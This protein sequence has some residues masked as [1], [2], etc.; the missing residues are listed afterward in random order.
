MSSGIYDCCAKPLGAIFQVCHRCEASVC[1]KCKP[2]TAAPLGPIICKE[3]RA[4]EWCSNCR[5]A[6]TTG[7][8][9]PSLPLLCLYESPAVGHPA[10]DADDWC[11][12]HEPEDSIDE[13]HG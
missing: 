2:E 1:Q 9:P 3:C 4:K 11:G 6:K 5:F 13:D 10:V 7:W 12:R 8:G